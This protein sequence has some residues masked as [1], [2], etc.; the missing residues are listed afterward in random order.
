M[1]DKHGDEIARCEECH[2]TQKTF[3]NGEWLGPEHWVCSECMG[4]TRVFTMAD[5][6]R[7]ERQ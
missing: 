7:E 4:E 5:V 6:E 1:K 3:G 2:R